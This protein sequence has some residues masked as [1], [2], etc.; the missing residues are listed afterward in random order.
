[1][2]AYFTYFVV[3]GGVEGPSDTLE[4]SDGV[5]TSDAV[6]A[7]HLDTVLEVFW[8]VKAREAEDPYVI[9]VS[10]GDLEK[11]GPK[12]HQFPPPRLD[13][14]VPLKHT[15]NYLFHHSNSVC[16]LPIAH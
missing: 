13:I 6:Y 9:K 11:F 1:M 12:G 7:A 3:G 5:T 2:Q 8:E 16:S 14:R 15:R 10:P 4:P